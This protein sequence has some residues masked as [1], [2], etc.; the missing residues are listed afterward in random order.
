MAW[1]TFL[2][3]N[4]E[5]GFLLRRCDRSLISESIIGLQDDDLATIPLVISRMQSF[6]AHMQRGTSL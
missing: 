1:H 2:V 5:S 3:H 6:G 4:E